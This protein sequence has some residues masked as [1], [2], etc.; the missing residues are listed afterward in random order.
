MRVE[1][2][3]VGKRRGL[4]GAGTQEI[5]RKIISRRRMG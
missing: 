2:I 5:Q 3:G 1:G 4:L